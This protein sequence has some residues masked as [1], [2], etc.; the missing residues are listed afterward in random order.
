MDDAFCGGPDGASLN[1][2]APLVSRVATKSVAAIILMGDPR[3]V[4]GLPFNR[5]NATEG[6][7][8]D[9]LSL[10]HLKCGNADAASTLLCFDTSADDKGSLENSLPPGLRR[11]RVRRSRTGYS[12][13]ATRLTRSVPTARASRRTRV[14][15]RNTEKKRWVSSSAN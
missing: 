15:V 6:G 2:T 11:S 9:N 12:R 14:M 7:V 4:A 10:L 3:F 13:T 8:S 1:T 5:G